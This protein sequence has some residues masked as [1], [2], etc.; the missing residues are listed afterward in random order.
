MT[1]YKYN[2]YPLPKGWVWVKLADI[3]LYKKGK[4]PQTLISEYRDGYHPYILIEQ[5]EGRPPKGY[6]NDS[7]IP[8]A[9]K[10]DVLMVWDGSIG[11]CA[12]GIEGIIGSTLVALSPI[13]LGPKYLKYFIDHIKL[14]IQSH[15][16][17]SGLQHVNPEFFWNVPFPL[18]PLPEQHRIV[19]KVEEFST[20]LDTGIEALNKV[21]LQLKRYRQAVLKA[22]F[23]GKLT[24]DWREAHKG[25]IEP[26]S[27]LLKKIKAERAKSSKYKELPP[28]DTSNL[29]TVPEGWVWARVANLSKAIQYGTSEKANEDTTGMPIVR[30]GNIQEGKLVFDNLKYLPNEYP[31]LDDFMLQDGD[32]LFN[33]TNSAELVGKTAVY[34]SIHPKAIFA[35]YLIRI[36]VNREAYNPDL[37]S[38]YINSFYGRIYISTVISQQVGQANVNGTK[39]SLMPVPLFSIIEQNKVVEE[40]DRCFSVADEVE[41]TVEQSL[42][43]GEILRKS[44][45]KKAFEGKLVP[46]DPHDEPAE[47]LLEWIKA[48]KVRQQDSVMGT[49][50]RNKKNP[51]HG[52]LI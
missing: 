24:T 40:I 27:I 49:R 42:R 17:G 39:L 16:R 45:L 15:P 46:Q 37:L 20:R 12:I 19:A 30:M 1:D 43:Q 31:Q 8:I 14:D 18:P 7:H 9:K 41:K 29:P 28:L 5:L 2:Q 52:R 38:Y 26:A 25:E 11:K 10:D 51:N 34:K 21:K 35:S 32:V 6:T 3:C 48:E 36:K 50:G 13:K 47:K 33:R 4:K 23:K 44:I 22:A